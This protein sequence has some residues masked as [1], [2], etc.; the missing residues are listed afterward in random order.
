MMFKIRTVKVMSKAPPQA[1]RTQ[2]SYGL[3]A[4]WKI[5][6]GKLAI[7]AFILVDMN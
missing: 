7:G 4:N 5:T 2:L 6:T 3:M 1:R